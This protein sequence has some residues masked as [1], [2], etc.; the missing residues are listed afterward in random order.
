[1]PLRRR[2]GQLYLHRDTFRYLTEPS[3]CGPSEKSALNFNSDAVFGRMFAINIGNLIS[4]TRRH[5]P[6]DSRSGLKIIRP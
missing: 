6:E 4:G 1:M 2:Q 3:C 5:V